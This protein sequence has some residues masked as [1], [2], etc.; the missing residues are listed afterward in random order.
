ML[1]LKRGITW[2]AADEFISLLHSFFGNNRKKMQRVFMVFL[3]MR[4]FARNKILTHKKPYV[5]Y[6]R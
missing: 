5:I 1:R 3:K 2:N 6:C 4:I